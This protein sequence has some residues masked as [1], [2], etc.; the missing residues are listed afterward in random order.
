[1]EVFEEMVIMM[2]HNGPSKV[3]EYPMLCAYL[4]SVRPYYSPQTIVHLIQHLQQNKIIQMLFS[5]LFCE[6]TK[7]HVLDFD[8]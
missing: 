7:G 4:V 3:D 5:R 6:V 1:M 8:G 2:Y